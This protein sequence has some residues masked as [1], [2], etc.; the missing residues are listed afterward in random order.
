MTNI[1]KIGCGIVFENDYFSYTVGFS[2]KVLSFAD[3]ADGKNYIANSESPYFCYLNVDGKGKTAEPI[4]ME[5]VNGELVFT[6]ISGAYLMVK[7]E[8][9][10]NYITFEVAKISGIACYSLVFANTI[11]DYPI[12][13]G[14]DTFG[15]STLAM[16][17]NTKSVAWP[18]YKEMKA[19]GVAY[20]E[21]GIDGAKVAIFGAPISKHIDF[22]KNIA[23]DIPKGDA[24]VAYGVG[25]PWARE[26]KG[27]RGD[28]IIISA[29][30]PEQLANDLKMYTDLNVDQLDFHKGAPF[31]QGD[32]HFFTDETGKA[33]AF[34][35]KMVS[36][37]TPHGIK[38]GLHT[39]SF[40]IDPNAD[41]L[42]TD[43]KWQKQLLPGEKYVLA[44]DMDADAVALV[45]E[46]NTDIA[47]RITG[48]RA[49]V[50]EYI[51]IDE[52]LIKISVPDIAENGF[53][54][55]TRGFAKT[56]P[57][58]HKKGAKIYRIASYYS[59]LCPIIGSDLYFEVARRTAKAY[60][61]GGF[62]MIYFD[63]LDGVSRHCTDKDLSWYYAAAFVNEVLKYTHDTPIAEMSFFAPPFYLARGRA[64]AWDHPRR[65]YKIWNTSHVN[66]NKKML[67]N[68][69]CAIL[70]WYN[71][72]PVAPAQ[73]P[74]STHVK[75][76]FFDDIDHMASLAVAYDYG[77]VYQNVAH[78]TLAMPAFRR[79]TDR[80]AK[81]NK[82]RKENYFPEAIRRKVRDGKYE[83]ALIEK[84]EG[85][86]AFVERAY[87]PKKIINID[88]DT[89]N[90]TK[91][92]NPFGS[93]KPFVRFEAFPVTRGND[94]IVALELDET[95]ELKGQTLRAEYPVLDPLKAA[96]HYGVHVKVFG[97]GSDTDAAVIRI[98]GV[99]EGDHNACDYFIPLNFNGW[100]DFY[101]VD[102]DNREYDDY[103]FEGI[104][105]GGYLAL[106]GMT[107]FGRIQNVQVYLTGECEGVKMSSIELCEWEINDVVDPSITVGG[108][109]LTFKC[110]LHGGEYIEYIEGTE[111][112]IYDKDGNERPVDAVVGS[113]TV[114]SGDFTAK[115]GRGNI[116]D[117]NAKTRLTFGLT[118]EE[119]K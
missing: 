10:E 96:N 57:A 19:G 15:M 104:E 110:T 94:P 36:Q 119:I 65:G 42:L 100:K 55:L 31:R 77:M 97:N 51:L 112:K 2:G 41:G 1:S 39:Y 53:G 25:G 54:C 83:Y 4:N 79:N 86:Y 61:E 35:E 3:K 99:I 27:E 102:L 52:E 23:T 92:S 50:S 71:L 106:R 116:G 7:P 43:P 22:L 101:L 9:K 90:T 11:V 80:Y 24:P 118:G 40:Y 67:D 49:L 108:E 28:Y 95:K 38:A 105:Q 69:L 75:Y 60:N 73:F 37:L 84:A 63:A 87:S 109:T 12:V 33:S 16:K 62:G 103:K 88:D 117:C 26:N 82:L 70:G 29:A 21:I 56:K 64:G 72:Y 17:V 45:T 59:G 81:Y 74:P 32:F 91:H 20:S 113:I 44:E 18:S 98:Q 89:F 58:A 111:A 5:Y 76:E 107:N 93:Q 78:N 34:K 66:S 30:T 68:Y 8:V 115:V 14:E 47:S 13:E 46:E 85:D 6:F 48:Y 114:P